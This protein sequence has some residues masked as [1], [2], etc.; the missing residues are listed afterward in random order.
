MKTTEL[1]QALKYIYRKYNNTELSDDVLKNF[2][3]EV[4][5]EKNVS[6]FVSPVYLEP[7]GVC[8]E[9]VE[10]LYKEKIYVVLRSSL[11]AY[12]Q[13]KIPVGRWGR[14]RAKLSTLKIK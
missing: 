7:S 2:N 14:I 4:K 5:E 8:E 12:H 11:S 13:A 10:V 1:N 3:T 9:T 6:V